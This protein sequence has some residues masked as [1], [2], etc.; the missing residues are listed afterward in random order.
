MR[1]IIATTKVLNKHEISRLSVNE[2]DTYR[3]RCIYIY[4][5]HIAQ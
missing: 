5:P 1:Y 4:I 2:S 3:G